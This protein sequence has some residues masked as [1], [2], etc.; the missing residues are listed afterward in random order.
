MKLSEKSIKMLGKILC[1]DYDFMPYLKGNELVKLF[2]DFGSTDVYDQT[3]PSRW[4]YTED[5]IREF[6][7][8]SELKEII[9]TFV[10]PRNFVF[11]KW[12]VEVA[13]KEL[14]KLLVLDGYEFR[15]VKNHFFVYNTNT[16]LV[17]AIS[18]KKL[19][20]DYIGEQIN[21]CKKK[22]E[23]GDY[24]GAITNARTLIEAIMIEIIEKHT[25]K[26]IINDGD[27]MKLFKQLKKAL[28]LETNP[29]KHP[30]FIIQILSG[31]SSIVSG[32][33]GISNNMGD[34]HAT[35]YTASKHHAKIAVNC[36]LTLSDFLL[37]SYHYQK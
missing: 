15:E 16:I 19:N 3:F 5:K 21:K 7:D 31:L 13:V 2:N 33:S 35:K 36:A 14:N 12:D 10:D 22:M 11:T 4:K 28:N 23:E 34:R 30:Q 25:G 29:E 8:T 6:N 18:T 37:D 24:H 26:E 9:E 17:D 1:G 32:L 27:I 20:N